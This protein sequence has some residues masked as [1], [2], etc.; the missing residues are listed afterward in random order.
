MTIMK[1]MKAKKKTVPSGKSVS[2]K[3]YNGAANKKVWYNQASSYHEQYRLYEYYV[4]QEER[5][6]NKAIDGLD[7]LLQAAK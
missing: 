5:D 4:S 1:N 7:Y 2:S 3:K 6:I